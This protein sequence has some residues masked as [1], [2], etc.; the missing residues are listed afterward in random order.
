[1]TPCRWRFLGTVP[2]REA[3][4]LQRDLVERRI[5]KEIPDTLLLVEHPP[6]VT[7]GKTAKAAHVLASRPDVEVV[8]TDRGGDVTFHGPGQI[9]GYPIMDLAGLR[10]DVKWYVERLEE[11]MIRTAGRWGVAA[12]PRE[13]MTGAWTAGGKIGAIGVRVRRWVTSHGF[14]FNVATDLS[15]FDLIV[16]C[17]LH[18]EGVT[19]LARELGRPVD[20]G[21]VRG[22][23]VAEFGGVFGRAM[24]HEEEPAR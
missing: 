4:A 3:L 5:A 20:P 1:M 9:V 15:Y 12:A 19:S 13:G 2:Y 23:L 7:L 17:G 22:A 11:V 24:E 10:Q 21:E 14:A 6:V 8:E 18:G 16:A